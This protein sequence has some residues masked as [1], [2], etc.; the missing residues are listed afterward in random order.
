MT[1]HDSAVVSQTNIWREGAVAG[2]V[3]GVACVLI[4]VVGNVFGLNWEVTQGGTT[5][6]VLIFMPFLSAFVSALVSLVV[7]WILM[8]AG[9]PGWWKVIVGVVGVLSVAQPMVAA[10]ET[11]TGLTLALMHLV[12]TGVMLTMV[13]P[14][15]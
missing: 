8:K 2:A 5:T 1:A 4:W 14:P 7:L 10:T 9:R 11:S 3:A 15:R 12:V 6:D 13:N